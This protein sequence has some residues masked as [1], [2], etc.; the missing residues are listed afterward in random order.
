M[1]ILDEILSDI[2]PAMKK[3]SGVWVGLHWTAVKSVYSGVSHTLKTED[4]QSIRNGGNLSSMRMDELCDMARSSNTLEASVGCA[5][6]NSLIGPRG[7]KGNIELQLRKLAKGKIIS[8]IGRFPFNDEMKQLAKRSYVIEINPAPGELP[9]TAADD[10]L[11]KCDLNIITATTMIN[12]TIDHLLSLGSGGTNVILGPTTPFSDVLF[13]H[14]ADILAG[15]KVNDYEE[16]V[17]TITQG[18][19]KFASIGGI[20]PLY[21]EK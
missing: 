4:A 3:P 7:K 21:L 20:E 10:V 9:S 1:K 19:K 8:I 6:I 18:V 12:H 14:G 15:V 13:A 17:R 5:A 11:P 16:L 2:N